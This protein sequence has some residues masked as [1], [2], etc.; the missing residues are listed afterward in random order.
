MEMVR[1]AWA[2]TLLV[3]GIVIAV[4]CAGPLS[5]GFGM[6]VGVLMAACGYGML[7]DGGG[8]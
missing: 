2:T 3:A 6:C 4:A 5:Y 7:I 1:V 8:R